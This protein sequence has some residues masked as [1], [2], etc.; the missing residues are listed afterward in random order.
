MSASIKQIAKKSKSMV[1]AYR[2]YDNWRT[3]KRFHSGNTES[4]HGS[5]HSKLTL[6]ES[7]DYIERVFEDYLTYSQLSLDAFRDKKILEVGP[8][9]NFGVALKFLAA[10][11][12]QVVCLDKFYSRRNEEQQLNIY[13]ALRDKME[14]PAL[15]RFDCAIKLDQGLGL[16]P[17]KLNYVHGIGIEEANRSFESESFDFIISRAVIQDVYDID[18]AFSAMD[19]LLVPGGYMLHKIDFSDQGMFSRRGMNPLTFLTIPEPIYRLM[20]VDS[21]K[22]NRK[23]GSYYR[24][25]ARE[26][27]YDAKLF[28]TAIFGRGNLIPHKEKIKLNTDYSLATVSMIESIRSKLA[29]GFKHLT[30]EELLVSGGFLIAQKPARE[31]AEAFYGDDSDKGRIRL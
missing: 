4:M 23:L 2:I 5:T 12:E 9:D 15:E 29:T 7:L 31:N 13:K 1:I 6:A 22:P 28:V 14:G 18:A 20:A 11:A 16:N 25:K 27:N 3:K 30:T 8:G 17:N 19:G 24:Q 26:F 10:G 21:G